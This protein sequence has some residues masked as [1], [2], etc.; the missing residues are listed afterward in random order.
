[1]NK[2]VS[3]LAYCIVPVVLLVL[4]ACSSHQKDLQA[5]PRILEH[6]ASHYP[7]LAFLIEMNG[8]KCA[9]DSKGYMGARPVV[10]KEV[11]GAKMNS[12]DGVMDALD[13]N[14]FLVVEKMQPDV[15]VIKWKDISP[16]ILGAHLDHIDFPEDDRYSA[17]RSMEVILSD[18]SVQQAAKIAN[19][20]MGLRFSSPAGGLV[21][22]GPSLDGRIDDINVERAMLEVLKVFRGSIVYIECVKPDG[23]TMFNAGYFP[24]GESIL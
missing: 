24:P 10:W 13:E 17:H 22:D 18:K 6:V 11:A 21:K 4:Q 5:Q 8:G 2:F 9:F 20:K 12:V 19:M 14:S 7:N 1:M 3:F 15:A 23:K 16:N